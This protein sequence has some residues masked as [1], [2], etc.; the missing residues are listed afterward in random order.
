MPTPP[1]LLAAGLLLTPVGEA[2]GVAPAPTAESGDPRLR[3]HTERVEPQAVQQALELRVGEDWQRWTVD[4]DDGTRPEEL[5]VKL[6]DDTGRIHTRALTLEGSTVD[7]RSRELAA[8]LALLVE[9]L[10]HA[11]APAEPPAPP[12]PV[13]PR[14]R[15]SG[16][17]AV[18][19]RGA[20]NLSRQAAI[21]GGVSLVGGAWL[22][23]DHVQPLVELAWAHSRRGELRVDALRLGAGLLGGGAAGPRGR[24]WGG[25]GALVRAQWA[26]ATAAATVDG[27]WASPA[28]VGAIQYRGRML[29]LGAWLGTDLVLPPLR[30]RGDSHTLRWAMVRPMATLHV[31]LRLPRRSRA[32][33]SSTTS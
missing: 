25:A 11:P 24:L 21:D 29:V 33:C 6:R 16:F 1:L 32:V 8:S 4:V 15:V 18:G 12:P 2:P 22:G 14:A 19:P 23:R 28:L 9:Q 20:L 10:A 13:E 27:W 31:G 26:Q 3:V 5:L 7:E 30:A 17:V